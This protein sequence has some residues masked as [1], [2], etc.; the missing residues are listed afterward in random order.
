M[1]ITTPLPKRRALVLGGRG[2][3]GAAIAARLQQDGLDVTV[4]GSRDFDMASPSEI[5]AWVARHGA[6]F[7]VLVHSAGV[8]LPKLFE[9][10]SE[11]AVRNAMDV[12]L[13]G[14]LQV[15]RHCLP[16]WKA[17][18][19]GHLLVISSLYAQFGRR[20]RLPYVMAK[21][22]LNGAVKTLA[23]EWAE[24]GVLVNALSPGYIGT[25]MTYKNNPQAT[26]DR[27]TG[28]IPLRRLGT[29][30]D[31]G[32]VACFLCS[33]NNRYLTGQDIV[34]D[35]GFSAGGFHD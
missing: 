18:G 26:L 4:V 28:G 10:S 7:D 25:R 34:V 17:R 31:I 11:E 24:Y 13:H 35:G 12:N 3:I 6:A 15:A 22:A 14:F 5:D 20:G 29:P 8:N 33:T 1:A 27:Y 9:H 30:E 19:S 23:I 2:E 16:H 32:E 21:H